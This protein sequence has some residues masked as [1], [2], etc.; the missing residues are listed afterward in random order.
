M[1]W[2]NFLVCFLALLTIGLAAE[3]G[4]AP[5]SLPA[6]ADQKG[7][8][9]PAKPK[10]APGSTDTS[11]TP[12]GTASP[13]TAST[14]GGGTGSSGGG[15]GGDGGGGGGTT[16]KPSESV[17]GA[18]CR[19]DPTISNIEEVSFQFRTGQAPP[20]TWFS[21]LND[22][23]TTSTTSPAAAADTKAL[24]R[25]AN[26]AEAPPA[27]PGSTLT[28]PKRGGHHHQ[29][30]P[31]DLLDPS[32][33]TRLID[34]LTFR[35]RYGSFGS[36]LN[37]AGCA[38]PAFSERLAQLEEQERELV[39][40]YTRLH[41]PIAGKDFR[42]EAMFFWAGLANYSR[43]VKSDL[44]QTVVFYGDGC[45]ANPRQGLCVYAAEY[46][47]FRYD[48]EDHMCMGS[49]MPVFY[50]V[51]TEMT[52]VYR[53][54]NGFRTQESWIDG[55]M[56]S[57]LRS[58]GDQMMNSFVITQECKGCT[59]PLSE[60]VYSNIVIK[61]SEPELHFEALGL[62]SGGATTTMPRMTEGGRVW[63]IDKVVV[64]SGK[65]V[66]STPG[67]SS[68]DMS[69]SRNAGTF[70]TEAGAGSGAGAGA[71]TGGKVN[72]AE[73]TGTNAKKEGYGDKSGAANP[74]PAGNTPGTLQPEE[75]SPSIENGKPAA[76]SATGGGNPPAG[77]P[78]A[79]ATSPQGPPATP[80][81][82]TAGK[83]AD[84]VNPSTPAGKAKRATVHAADRAGA[85]SDGD[86]E[87]SA[88]CVGAPPPPP[89][90]FPD[91]PRP[92]SPGGSG[93]SPG[94][95]APSEGRG[96]GVPNRRRKKPPMHAKRSLI[97][98]DPGAP[99]IVRAS[100]SQENPDLSGYPLRGGDAPDGPDRSGNSPGS[101]NGNHPP[102]KKDTHADKVKRA[103]RGK[104]G[105]C[106]DTDNG[107][108][109][110]CYTGTPRAGGLPP[111]PPPGNPGDTPGES[112]HS[113]GVPNRRRRKPP[114]K[115]KRSLITEDPFS[116]L[117]ARRPASTSGR[118]DQ[119]GPTFGA[120]NFGGR[121]D[122]PEPQGKPVP[123]GRPSTNDPPGGPGTG[124]H[125]LKKNADV[126]VGKTKRAA[127]GRP[128]LC[129]DSPGNGSGSGCTNGPF[130]GG[131]SGGPPQFGGG[132]DGGPGNSDGSGNGKGPSVPPNRRRRKPP[133][134]AKRSLI[135]SDPVTPLVV[136]QGFET[137]IRGNSGSHAS[138]PA[139][140]GGSGTGG[141]SGGE[142]VDH[143]VGGGSGG[144]P[145]TRRR[146]PPMKAKRSLI[147]AEPSTPFAVRQVYDSPDRGNHGGPEVFD[148]S[149]GGSG[150]GGGSGGEPVDHR[151]GGGSGGAPNTRRR[152]PP[153]KSKR[154]LISLEPFTPLVI[155]QTFNDPDNGSRDDHGD[156]DTSPDS[157]ANDNGGQ[158]PP[159]KKAD[160]PAGKVKRSPTPYAGEPGACKDGFPEHPPGENGSQNGA[161]S[162]GHSSSP[163]ANNGPPSTGGNDPRH[164]NP[165]SSNGGQYPN[166]HPPPSC[167]PGAP[168]DNGGGH[169]PKGKNP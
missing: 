159:K 72:P 57:Y 74:G 137:P 90:G 88:G 161:I 85:C 127:G 102:S 7:N 96:N 89:G 168:G 62:C 30:D 3:T 101:D 133:V 8:P 131:G 77:K 40:N 135:T 84:N 17:F 41:K 78:A 42:P 48:P 128:G 143:R 111:P 33:H 146:K 169:P 21:D 19:W 83:P 121:S 107:S 166:G 20:S 28:P 140:P 39:N 112:G 67:D 142:P 43:K 15:A 22:A 44:I 60:Q 73:D 1:L 71:N 25:R 92:G 123:G 53:T 6:G 9:D 95:G 86:G 99:L 80:A 69:D 119:N 29:E 49:N 116:L 154:S 50:P 32:Y 155:R 59:W 150:T 47:D 68:G 81:G 24:H 115:T 75:T 55:K 104:V 106:G 51:D 153:M 145:N 79:P 52:V 158:I 163:G 23:E 136:R 5:A 4:A 130:P 108:S 46:S 13:A 91:P 54:Q 10:P 38:L 152:K 151:V 18:G 66:T 65:H 26:E 132:G 118:T 160:A 129:D 36:S 58:A 167:N 114:M 12:G 14:G 144:A 100:E 165:G 2:Q 27:Q 97:P 134:K 98:S 11:T 110:S 82:A 156:G 94:F 124:A 125:K 117:V 31:N 120:P 70:T 105:A 37:S 63:V 93:G 56:I 157:S 139:S 87:P 103:A 113:Y 162:G 148:P 149:P 126:I 164:D 122:A 16:Q 64:P 61:F 109:S 147:P 138:G 34:V 35:A 76:V 141:G 45:A